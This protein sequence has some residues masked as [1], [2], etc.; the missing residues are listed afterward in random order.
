MTMTATRPA[1]VT[2]PSDFSAH[3]RFLVEKSELAVVKGFELERW[4]RDPTREDGEVRA[5]F[6][7]AL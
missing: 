2:V 4:S 1:A 5:V 6:E 7:S 3:D